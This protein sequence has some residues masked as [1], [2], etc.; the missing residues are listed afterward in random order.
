MKKQII[1]LVIGV[2]IGAIITTGVFL[3]VKPNNRRSLPNSSQT[4]RGKDAYN[5]ERKNRVNSNTK[6][7]ETT[8][9]DNKVEDSSNENKG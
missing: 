9:E 7:N 5:R 2:L 3:I 8:S 4:S 6:N 1:T